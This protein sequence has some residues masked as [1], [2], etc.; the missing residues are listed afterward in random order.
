MFRLH[1]IIN[2]NI[3]NNNDNTRQVY[4]TS[5]RNIETPLEDDENVNVVSSNG[6]KYVFN[7]GTQYVSEYIIGPGEYI[8]R[9]VPVEHPIALLNKG[10][11]DIVKYEPLDDTPILIK[12][13][14]GSFS[15]PYYNFT[16]EN[17]NIIDING[18][19]FK[20]M[21]GRT[22][23]FADYGVS[24]S[25]PFKIVAT[26]SPDKALNGS[27]SDGTDYIDLKMDEQQTTSNGSVYYQCEQHSWMR[28]NLVILAKYIYEYQEP[29]VYDTYDFYYGDVK[30]TVNGDFGNVSVYCLYHGYM[31]GKDILKYGIISFTGP[32]IKYNP[33]TGEKERVDRPKLGELGYDTKLDTNSSEYDAN[34]NPYIDKENALY[35]ASKDPTSVY[36]AGTDSIPGNDTFNVNVWMN[37]VDGSKMQL[38]T[39]GKVSSNLIVSV[40]NVKSLFTTNPQLASTTLTE[41]RTKNRD[42][43]VGLTASRLGFNNP[44]LKTD[45]I[46]RSLNIEDPTKFDTDIYGK[47]TSSVLSGTLNPT[48]LESITT[49]ISDGASKILQ[50]G[51]SLNESKALLSN[52]FITMSE[53]EKGAETISGKYA[54]ET[55]SDAEILAKVTKKSQDAGKLSA[56][57]Y[58]NA[59]EDAVSGNNALI[60]SNK[61]T[62]ITSVNVADAIVKSGLTATGLVAGKAHAMGASAAIA[63][64]ESLKGA[65]LLTPTNKDKQ[66]ANDNLSQEVKKWVDEG[67]LPLYYKNED[68]DG[69]TALVNGPTEQEKQDAKSSL[70][71]EQKQQ[72]DDG[73]AELQMKWSNLNQKF[74]GDGVKP[75]DRSAKDI[76]AKDRS[77]NKQLSRWLPSWERNNNYLQNN[78]ITTRVASS[79]VKAD[80]LA[81]YEQLSS[82]LNSTIISGLLDEGATL[83]GVMED[84]LTSAVRTVNNPDLTLVRNYNGGNNEYSGVKRAV[85]IGINY[86]L[87]ATV[88]TLDGCINDAMAIRGVLIDTYQYKNENIAVLR[89]DNAVGYVNPTRENIINSIKNAAKLSKEEDELWIHFSGHGDYVDDNNKD[90]VD[91]RDE[92]IVSSDFDN[93]TIKMILDDELKPLL[94]EVKGTVM[95]TQDCCNSGTGWDL[96]FKYT[97]QSDNTYQRTVEGPMFSHTTT[98]NIYMFSGSRDDQEAI[99]TS[100]R[101]G[102]FTHAFIESLRLRN[103]N[104][105][106]TQLEDDIN[107]YLEQQDL[108]QRTVFTSANYNIISAGITRAMI[109]SSNVEPYRA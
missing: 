7:N 103:H 57:N 97:K 37:A 107:K 79:N 13:S 2:K 51:G 84:L 3:S 87:N 74:E 52:Y 41:L 62:E 40:N 22:Y 100:D 6:N 69:F 88:N 8:L 108:E 70:P 67:L 47:A 10:K 101:L 48:Q 27:S 94:N 19:S 95:I 58:L 42:G 35:N 77:A 50:E 4:K 85:L 78:K 81:K 34:Y 53:I 11:S 106:F 5:S 49:I 26:N 25:H 64:L 104:V 30:I 68:S 36:F 86:A 80:V 93:D 76:S 21:R 32:F 89:D 29:N 46:G 99:E 28:G 75:K 90:E 109:T 17:N 98:D 1:N 54:K 71:D 43:F 18:G 45:I 12:V 44:T 23:R 14:G 20:F 72:I 96:P 63:S 33:N 82:V 83:N 9:N 38:N 31:G 16:D 61:D 73:T 39:Y 59:I 102:A 55:F 15:S 60:I 65:I 91:N 66:D 56:T 105:N 24:S 92:G